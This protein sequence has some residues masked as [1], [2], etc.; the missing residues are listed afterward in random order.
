MVEIDGG[1]CS[2]LFDSDGWLPGFLLVKDGKTNGTGGVDVRV[3]K[4]RGEL[5]WGRF[6]L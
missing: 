3:E 4:W 6:E 2:N 1:E 5:A